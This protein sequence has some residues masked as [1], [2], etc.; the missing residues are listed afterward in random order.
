[1]PIAQVNSVKEKFILYVSRIEERKNHLLLV[2][3][4]VE[5]EFWKLGYK[6]VLAGRAASKL[7]I[8]INI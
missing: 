5:G 1:M 6:L 8:Y 3:A 2:R 7:P 4:Y